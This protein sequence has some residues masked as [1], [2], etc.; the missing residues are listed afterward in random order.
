METRGG[1]VRRRGFLGGVAGV[2]GLGLAGRAGAASARAAVDPGEFDFDTGNVIRDLVYRD[3]VLADP[4][5]SMDVSLIIRVTHL[6]QNAWFDALAPYHPTAVG[7]YS[8]LGRRPASERETNRNKNIA[9]L[10]AILRVFENVIPQ[11]AEDRRELLRSLGL[12]PEDRSEDRTTPAGIGNLAARGVV[13]NRERDG[14]NQLGDEGGRRYHPRP[15]DDYTGYAP[16]NS[17]YELTDPSHW[18]PDLTPHRRRMGEGISDFGAYIVQQFVTPQW[19]LTRPYSFED[20]EEFRTDPPRSSDHRNAAAYRRQVDEI[21]AASA[22]LTDAQKITAEAFDNKFLGIGRAVSAAAA[23]H[24]LDLDGWVHLCMTAS[25]ATFDA[26]VVVWNEKYRHNAVRP[27][28]AVRHVYGDR[29]VRAWGGPGRGTVDDLPGREWRA[30]LNVGDHPEYPS[31]S[32][33]LATAQ[34]QASRRFLDSEELGWVLRVERGSSLVEPGRTPATDLELRW[35][36]WNAYV[37]DCGL[38]R[39]WGGVHFLSAV[40]A[41][42]ALGP[43][44]GDRAYEFVQAHIRGEA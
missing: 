9:L 41:S 10:Y 12:D 35:D 6:T 33:T 32:T 1:G 26:G 36:T 31:G 14:M 39:T 13:A 2:A 8:R 37:E 11:L 38:S 20:P 40:E 43:R 3:D 4:L 7:I 44:I 27:F 42:W 25:T 28:S 21:L 19:R 18:Q 30:Y 16:V 34:A 22:A 5:A 17:A 24:R 29:P 23:H 15:Y